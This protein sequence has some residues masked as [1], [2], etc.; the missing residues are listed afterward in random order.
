MTNYFAASQT[1]VIATLLAQKQP[2][3]RLLARNMKRL[4]IPICALVVLISCGKTDY[5]QGQN[6]YVQHC[7]NC[8]YEEGKGLGILIPPLDNSDWLKENQEKLACLIRNGMEGP[9]IVNDTTYNQL[10]PGNIE[11]SDFQITN[12]INYINH[13][14]GNDYGVVVLGDVR[15]Q[16]QS[17]P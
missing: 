15:N 4:F 10:M 16:L 13:A 5:Q 12:L 3:T 8:H 2:F 11:L 6:L 7:A 1:K 17:C 14:W 9:I